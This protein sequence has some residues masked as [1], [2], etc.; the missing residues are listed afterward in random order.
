M[1]SM[2]EAILANHDCGDL[3]ALV[4]VIVWA[5]RRGFDV[6]HLNNTQRFKNSNNRGRR[7]AFAKK[8]DRLSCRSAMI[9]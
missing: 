7:F 5:E 9:L 1:T 2:K 6:I 4:E 8:T 3:V